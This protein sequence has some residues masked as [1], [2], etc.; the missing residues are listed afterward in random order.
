LC[1]AILLI[2][3]LL[4]GTIFPIAVELSLSAGGSAG[5]VARGVGRLFAINTAGCIAGALTAGL[6]L[7][8]M[9]GM[10]RSLLAGAWLN[11]GLAAALGSQIPGATWR[12]RATV[13]AAPLVAAATLAAVTPAWDPI[14]MTTGVYAYAARYVKVGVDRYRSAQAESRLIYYREGPSGTVSVKENR[15]SRALSIDGRGEGNT[16]AVAQI[17]LGQLPFALGRPIGDVFVIGLGTG[18][19]AGALTLH[20]VRRIEVVEIE[21]A[22]IQASA[23]FDAINHRPL[24]DA[25]VRVRVNDAR[26]VLVLSPPSSYDLIVSQ[27]STPWVPGASKLFTVEFYELVRA[28]LRPEGI[29][30]QWVQLYNIDR[31]SLGALLNTLTRVFPQA[32]I[33]EVGG[34][35]GEVLFIATRDGI[36]LSWPALLRVFADDR[37]A[38]DL[39]RVKV[40]NPGTVVS[41][42]LLGPRELPALVA[43]AK[44]NT[45]DNGLL[46]FSALATLY[47]DTTDA[48][49]AWLRQA[50]GAPWS[51][52]SEAPHGRARQR[53]LVEMADAAVLA[54]DFQRGLVFAGDAVE[55]GHDASALRVLGD[56]LYVDGK[57]DAAAD[58]WRK[59]LTLEPRNVKVLRRLVRHY[60]SLPVSARPPE[61]KAW[62]AKLD[63]ELTA[64]EEPQLAEEPRP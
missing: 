1:A 22:V 49:L 30:A 9:I 58:G 29:F 36:A 42:V 56:L 44:T 8:P 43:G 33:V 26:T 25:R 62:L 53:A 41:R 59:A 18:S 24:D 60:G 37:I 55:I 54:R 46:E 48:N 21:P 63:A 28:R 17:L 51:Y 19:T 35:S 4:M 23:L 14:T 38:R 10:R 32:L 11:L 12:F 64:P 15:S 2:P 50:A 20:P 6:L 45:D 34:N 61:Y 31:A 39:A 16:N 52:V 5:R 57:R 40:A 13:M 7:I 3:A 47:H 27:P